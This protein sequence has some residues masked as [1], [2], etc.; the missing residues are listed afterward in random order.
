MA[1]DEMGGKQRAWVCA[2]YRWVESAALECPRLLAPDDVLPLLLVPA[3]L[4]WDQREAAFGWGMAELF[5]QRYGWLAL[6]RVLVH[7][8][9]AVGGFMHQEQSAD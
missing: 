9:E 3:R 1:A 2:G 7:L 4:T 5:E 8:D 6:V